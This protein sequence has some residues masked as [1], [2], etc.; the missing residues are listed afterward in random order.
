VTWTVWD[1][2]TAVHVAPDDDVTSHDLDGLDCLC[3]P[4]CEWVD[5]TTGDMHAR[6]MVT[7][8]SL[9]GR[10]QHETR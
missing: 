6:P 4:R 3:G 8:H 9:D 10:E 1:T 7:H 5:P 2:D